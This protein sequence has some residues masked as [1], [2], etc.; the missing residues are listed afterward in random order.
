MLAKELAGG[1]E[2][3]I[4]N[5]LPARLNPYITNASLILT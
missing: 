2:I 5:P 1:T 3:K 4:P